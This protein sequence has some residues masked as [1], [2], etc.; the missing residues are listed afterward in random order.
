MAPQLEVY[1]KKTHKNN[2]QIRLVINNIQAPSYKIACFMN[3]KTAG[4]VLFTI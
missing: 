2:Q 1:F 3:K 4:T